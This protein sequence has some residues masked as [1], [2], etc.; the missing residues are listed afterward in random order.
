MFS[1]KQDNAVLALTAFLKALKAP[2]TASTARKRLT[3]HPHYPSLLAV[4]DCLREWRIEHATA[5]LR[6]EQ[7]TDLNTPFFTQVNLAGGGQFTVVDSVLEQG[8]R[9]LNT[10]LG[11]QQDTVADFTDKWNPIV[12]L[13]ETTDASGE[14]DYP[15]KLREEQLAQAKPVFLTVAIVVG[16]LAIGLRFAAH[17]TGATPWPWNA[18]LL[19]KLVGTGLSI[20]LLGHLLNQRPLSAGLCHFHKAV[21]CEAVLNSKAATLWGG[22]SW[23]EIGFVYFAGS[24]LAL[25]AGAENTFVKTTLWG[26]GLL[27]LPYPLF[28]IYYQARVVKKWCTLCL[29]VQ[30]I[31]LFDAFLLLLSTKPALVWNPAEVAGLV[32]AF[33]LPTIGWVLLKP[34][35]TRSARQETTQRELN[36][37]WADPSLFAFLLRRQKPLPPL[38]DGFGSVSLG[39]PAGDH[40][41]T[42]VLNPGCVPC[43]ETFTTAERLLSV[44]DH[45]RVQVIF[46]TSLD[47]DDPGVPFVRRLY[48]LPAN[49]RIQAIRDWYEHLEKDFAT[50]SQSFLTTEGEGYGQQQLLVQHNWVRS[51]TIQATPAI[52]VNGYPLPSRY[53]L[54]DVPYLLKYGPPPAPAASTQ[55]AYTLSQARQ[56]A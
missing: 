21:D 55:A 39:N 50:W 47:E 20:H 15:Q 11:W 32:L 42:L 52:L 5:R 40:S 27:A 25:L 48:T 38:P 24:T 8:V 53:Q 17:M 2:V 30:S 3:R 4:T 46:A 26:L 35:L 13:A 23:S 1:Q 43:G 54:E 29:L 7:L 31:L 6:P 22:L 36:H 9:W 37:L 56:P 16:L 34:L 41:I 51:A 28:S 12:L 18:L 10:E 14:A 49:Q 45:L 33:L 44:H 19:T